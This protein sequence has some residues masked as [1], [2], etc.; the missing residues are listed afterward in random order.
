MENRKQSLNRSLLMGMS[1]LLAAGSAQAAVMSGLPADSWIAGTA[2]GDGT[3]S[4]G[5]ALVDVNTPNMYVGRY[6]PTRVTCAVLVFQL[7]TLSAGQRLASASLTYETLTQ[8]TSVLKANIDLYGLGYRATSTVTT[9]DYYT[10]ALDTTSATLL[11]DNLFVTETAVS[12]YS[13]LS[14]TTDSVI[15]AK[16]VDYLNAQYDAGAVGGNYVFIRFNYDAYT[17]GLGGRIVLA[18]ANNTT[19]GYAPFITY[20]VAAVPE[21]ASLGCLAM[22]GGALL[23]RRRK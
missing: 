21:P 8:A 11:A 16:L 4:T 12:P 9:G 20:N 6:D 14:H 10:G 3:N 23:L 13:D 15:S 17:T 18:T 22:A 5:A 19:A 2:A 1:L 7:P